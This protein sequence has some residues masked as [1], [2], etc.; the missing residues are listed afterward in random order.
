MSEPNAN[1]AGINL[2]NPSLNLMGR[3]SLVLLHAPTGRDARIL[4]DLLH[5]AKITSQ[6]CLTIEALA[7]EMNNGA[8]AMVISEEAFDGSAIKTISEILQQHKQQGGI[9]LLLLTIGNAL[10]EP[11]GE[12]LRRLESLGDLTLLERPLRPVTIV[13]AVRTALRARAKQYEVRRRDA[14]L[15]LITDNVPVLIS[16]ID[17]TQIFK[18]ANQTY[19]EWFGKRPEEI[20]GRTI[21]EIGGDFHHAIAQPYIARVLRG[22]RVSFESQIRSAD[23]EIRDVTVSYAPEFSS[24]GKVQGYIALLQDITE[25][26]RSERRNAF[27]VVLDDLTRPLSDPNK[28][29][30]TAAR[31]LGEELQVNRCAYTTVEEDQDTFNLTGGYNWDVP[32]IIGRFT[33]TQ[34]GAECLR[35]MRE[36]VPYVV[37]DAETDAR[38]EGVRES[39]RTTCIRS[40]ICVSLRKEGRFVAAMAVNQITPRK[41]RTDEIELVQQVASRCWE[42]IER[43]RVTQQL[44][45]AEEQFRTL[46][47]TI[48]NLAWMANAD[49]HIFWY[50]QRWFNYTG[51]TQIEME[52]WGWQTVHDPEVLPLVLAAWKKSLAGGTALEM[53]FPLKGTD[54]LFRQFLTRVEPVRDTDGKV[55]RWFGTNTDITF[56]KKTEE[57]LRESQNQLQIALE[58]AKLGSWSLDLKSGVLTCSPYCYSNFGLERGTTFTYEMLLEMIHPQDRPQMQESVEKAIAERIDHHA[59]YRITRPDGRLGWIVSSG[60]A[61]YGE[62]GNPL[63]MVGVTLDISERKYAEEQLRCSNETLKRVNEDLEAFAYVASH[64]LQEPLRMVNSYSQLLL[65]R[66]APQQSSDIQKFADYIR[67]GV[68]RMEALIKDLLTYSRTT[69]AEGDSPGQPADLNFAL[70]QA[71]RRVDTRIAENQASVSSD[72]LPIVYGDEGQLAHV[73]QNLLSNALKY[74]KAAETPRIH[75][76]A[77]NQNG[78]WIV[79][80]TDNGIGFDQ[81]QAERIFGL[82]K[83]LHRDEEYP[84]TGVGLAICKRIVERY[85]GRMWAESKV[86]IGSTFYIALTEFPNE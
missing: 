28:V 43:A 40:V 53:V 10:T 32:S 18:R 16:Y 25:R 56:Q 83:R 63:Q 20:I 73:F 27:L 76:G 44:L 71:L 48:P 72:N 41:W 80:V 45:A 26:K 74:R 75:I 36:G 47:N 37:D 38:T 24:D 29:A 30:R 77:E 68:K 4:H 81:N 2:V 6:I 11:G 31:L 82:F 51:T 78:Q 52:G 55:V 13:S 64:D 9:Q 19:F 60:R 15:Q 67:T 42:S 58:T 46:A 57:E 5:N 33:F 84:G 86:G 1:Y 79:S 66:L 65:L 34:F 12:R 21:K 59:E 3:D 62:T 22:E 85:Q 17:R 50:N 14:E 39:Y 35:L 69:H 8:G 61:L 7:R 49:G 70:E 23:N 54:G